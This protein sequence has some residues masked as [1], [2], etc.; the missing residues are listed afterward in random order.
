MTFSRDSDKLIYDGILTYFE[1]EFSYEPIRGSDYTI[2]LG[3]SY[4]GLD[5]SINTN[6]IINITGYCSKHTWI[7]KA[8]VLPDDIVVGAVRF[9]SDEELLR[10]LG[11]YLFEE[12]PI[13]YDKTTNWCCI[14]KNLDV[15]SD[16]NIE[17][18]RNCIL[19]LSKGK[20]VALWLNPEYKD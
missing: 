19:S 15:K 2:M 9:N 14:T 20:F 18:A 10:G 17:F 7:P 8:L 4:L 11:E 1:N 13:Y 16:E 5:I 6:R 12:I 3:C